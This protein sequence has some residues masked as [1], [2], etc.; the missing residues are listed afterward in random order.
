MIVIA[1]SGSTKTSWA[2]L[3]NADEPKQFSTEGYNP[4]YVDAAYIEE[5]IVKNFSYQLEA[6]KVEQ[7]YF[8]GA[9][10]AGGKDEVV[11]KALTAIFPNASIFVES[12]LLAAAKSLLGN[13]EG[14]ISI[15]GTGTN[16]GIYSNGKIISQVN[17]LGFW[18]GDEGSGAYLG[19]KLLSLFARRALPIA[20]MEA[21]ENDYGL[22]PSSVIPTFYDVELQNR[23]TAKFTIF[24]HKHLENIYIRKL[25]KQAF[26]DF[27]ENIVCLYPNYRNYA[28]NSIGSV[29]LT[30][31]DQLKEVAYSYGMNVG[32]INKSPIEGLIEYHQKAML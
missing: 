3:S 23:Y 9:G 24:L 19:K 15:L 18:L 14:F 5:S 22:T 20:L 13:K 31:L 30:F 17:S 7:V 8:Y 2:V 28:L 26:V 27:F 29:G 21:F 4:Y 10:C 6:D 1:D 12:D 32:K 25:V 16:T 11:K